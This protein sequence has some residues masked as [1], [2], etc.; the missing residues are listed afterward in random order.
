MKSAPEFHPFS[1]SHLVVILLTIVVPFVL[2][3]IVHRTKSRFLQRSICFAISA[4]LLINYVAY[5]IVARQFGVAEWQ[6]MLPMQ[7]C[8][9]A[10]I[11]IIGA[12]WT[13]NRRWLEVAYFWGIGGTLQAIVTPNLQFGFPDLRFISFFVAHSGIIIGIIFLMLIYGFRPRAI[14]ILRTFAWTEVYFVVAFTTDLL[15][16]ENY[17][18]LLHKPEAASLLSFLSDSRPLYLLEF[19]ILAFVF[20]TLLY[21]PFAIVDLVRGKSLR[22]VAALRR[23]RKYGN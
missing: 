5:L 12:L 11:V 20:F 1:P 3:V 4:L 18:F 9:W 6:K 21:A 14:G 13:G 15:T 16:G 8:D 19:H 2:A 22:K 7:L 10:M 17:G 23:N